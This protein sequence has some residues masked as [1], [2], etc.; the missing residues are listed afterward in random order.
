[1][2]GSQYVYGVFLPEFPKEIIAYPVDISKSSPLMVV[3][4][5]ALYESPKLIPIGSQMHGQ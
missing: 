3:G 5:L 2:V 1:M 4:L